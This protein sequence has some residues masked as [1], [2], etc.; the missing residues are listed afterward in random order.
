MRNVFVEFCFGGGRVGEA[1]EE[2]VS[3]SQSAWDE[4][5]ELVMDSEVP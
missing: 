5:V 4:D 2:Y 3:S 1:E